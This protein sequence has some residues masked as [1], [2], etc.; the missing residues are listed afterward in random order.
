MTAPTPC[1]LRRW[2]KDAFDLLAAHDRRDFLTVATPG[3]GKTTFATAAARRW[4]AAGTA[5]GQRRQIVVVAPTRHLT[6]QW[7]ASA[8]RLGLTLADDVDLRS[9]IP[10]DVHGVVTTYQQLATDP[11]AAAQTAAGT[12]AVL[13]EVHHA[14]GELTWGSA[15]RTVFAQAHARLALSGTPFRSDSNRIPFIAYDLDEAAPDFTYS[16]RDALTDGVVRPVRFTCSGG[17]MEWVDQD[18]SAAS[19]S[20]DDQLDP[21]A[22]SQR[23]RTA[24]DPAGAWLPAVLDQAHQR[25]RSQQQTSPDVGGLVLATDQDHARRI[26]Q[27][28]AARTGGEVTLAVSDDRDA[29]AKLAR[30][31]AGHGDWLVSVRLVSEGVDIPRLATLVWATTTTTELFFRQAVGRVVRARAGETLTAEVLLP[32]DLR[33]RGCANRMGVEVR[34]ALLRPGNDGHLASGDTGA[35][36]DPTPPD[37]QMPS[38]FVAVAAAHDGTVHETAPLRC[39]TTA[40]GAAAFEVDLP[41]LLPLPAAQHPELPDGLT[42]SAKAA[43]LRKEAA[44]TVARI[45]AATGRDHR[46]VNVELN[47]HVGLARVAD[48]T[49]AQ[50]HQRLRV[51]RSLLNT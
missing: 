2:Q 39:S 19:A 4:I 36:P 27:L 1:T 8:Q 25:L 16:Y 5:S 28:L 32:D 24:L 18:G 42:H 40:S 49:L 22:A 43:W 17:H 50:L 9:P 21:L 15:L 3:A 30:Y 6:R 7:A 38:Q 48:A 34:H 26:A 11:T 12:L 31:A 47:Q 37:G 33:L 46:S 23:L 45:V 10:A 20:F 51:A 41:P 13:D 14:G 44:S 29:A 35:L